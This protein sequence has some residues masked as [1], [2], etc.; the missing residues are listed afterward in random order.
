MVETHDSIVQDLCALGVVAG[1][2]LLVHSSLSQIGRVEG[3]A[4][5]VIAALI[6]AVAPG[7]NLLFPGHNWD[8]VSPESPPSFDVRNTPVS[9][10]G[11][12][13]EAARHFVG[14]VRSLQPTH[15]VTVIGPDAAWFTDGHLSSP[16]PCGL[17]SP[18]DKLVD[19]DGFILL[20]GCDHESNTSFHMAE[21]L[22]GAP[23]YVLPD[24]VL[25]TVTD[26]EGQVSVVECRLHT[27][28]HRDYMAFDP[29]LTELGIQRLGKIGNAEARLVDAALLRALL[30]EALERDPKALR[31][32][33]QPLDWI[34][35]RSGATNSPQ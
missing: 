35:R 9:A 6:D 24:R 4:D 26:A 28:G 18:Y 2:N 31:D 14:A 11:V 34:R 8:G 17:G 30:L 7:G 3:G 23:D 1:M 22:S 27:W 32:D 12:I 33:R 13:P 29:W 16:T 19:Q 20:L 25:A 15:S 10:V 21:E 5:T